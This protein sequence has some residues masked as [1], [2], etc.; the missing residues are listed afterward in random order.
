MRPRGRAAGL[1]RRLAARL[2]LAAALAACASCAGRAIPREELPSEPVALLWWDQEEMRRRQETLEQMRSRGGPRRR[3]VASLEGLGSLLGGAEQSEE[4]RAR[5]RRWPGRLVL[6]HPR[7]NEVER[8]E[9]APPGSRPLGWSPDHRQLLFLSERITGRAHLYLYDRTTRE[10][11][12]VTHGE[13]L[14]RAGSLGPDGRLAWIEVQ[15]QPLRS[16]VVVTGPDGR[17]PRALDLEAVHIDLAL[18]PDGRSLVLVRPDPRRPDD[19]P[20][21]LVQVAL[22]RGEERVLARGKDPAFSGDGRWLVYAASTPDGWRLAR[23]RADGAG[24]GPLG[25]GNR[26]EGTPAA[27][28]DGGFVVY[29]APA[30][31]V[32]KLFL[33]RIDGSGDRVLLD[34]GAAAWPVW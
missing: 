10:V 32:N 11:R 2:A 29:A 21:F 27:S 6:L 30:N 17:S 24:R 19:R 9:A 22:D 23:M 8:V 4:L 16:R 12:P 15:T 1:R 25:E 3:G 7:S 13:S 28:P 31:D 5:L 14:V 33:R 34:E 20:P 18:S 26:E